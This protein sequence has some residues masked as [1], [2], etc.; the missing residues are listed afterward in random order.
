MYALQHQ[1]GK[2]HT[3]ELTACINDIDPFMEHS[4]LFNRGMD[5]VFGIEAIV[6]LGPHRFEVYRSL[7]I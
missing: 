5:D 2:G 1:E 3:V 6:R 7:T 4:I